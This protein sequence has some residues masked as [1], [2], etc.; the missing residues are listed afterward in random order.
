MTE[1]RSPTD[2]LREEHDVALAEMARL[3]ET[4]ATLLRGGESVPE[5]A[6]DELSA[7]LADLGRTL[8]LHFRKEEEGL[9]PEVQ[10]MASEGA[11]RVDILSEFFGEEAEED[12]MAHHL[13]RGRLREVGELVQGVAEAGEVDGESSGRLRGLVESMQDLLARHARKESELVFPMVERL[14]DEKQVA[15]V[16]ER[17]AAIARSR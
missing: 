9:F 3:R 13:L 5:D 2:E 14:L 6:G 10:E 4:A 16:R 15:A 7:R 12:L 8:G 1:E 11:P 17:F